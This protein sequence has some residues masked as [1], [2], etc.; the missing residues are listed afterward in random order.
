MRLSA[1]VVETRLPD[2]SGCPPLIL[3]RMRRV[4]SIEVLKSEKC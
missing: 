2:M 4:V 1:R 3:A